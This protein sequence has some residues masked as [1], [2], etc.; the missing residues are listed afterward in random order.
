MIIFCIFRATNDRAGSLVHATR[1]GEAPGH[2]G[3]EAAHGGRIQRIWTNGQTCCSDS[4]EYGSATA[5]AT[6][7]ARPGSAGRDSGSLI[8]KD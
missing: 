5:A 7:R 1:R 6:S 8:L 2:G 3:D 4:T